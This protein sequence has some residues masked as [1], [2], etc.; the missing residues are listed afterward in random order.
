[1]SDMQALYLGTRN[2][3]LAEYGFKLTVF[4]GDSKEHLRHK[5]TLTVVSDA[6]K[7]LNKRFPC[8]C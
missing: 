3:E 7:H 4:L 2:E 5:I 6:G 1:M 8:F